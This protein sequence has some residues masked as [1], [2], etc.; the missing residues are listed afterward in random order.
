M[1]GARRL[2]SS[3][4]PITPPSSLICPPS[5]FLFPHYTSSVPPSLPPIFRPS[6]SHFLPR[7]PYFRTP[8][9]LPTVCHTRI[10]LPP[11]PEGAMAPESQQ[12]L[13][14][15]SLPGSLTPAPIRSEAGLDACSGGGVGGNDVEDGERSGRVD[16]EK[17]MDGETREEDNRAEDVREE[18]ERR[19][20]EGRKVVRMLQGRRW[21]WTDFWEEID[22]EVSECGSCRCLLV[23]S[24]SAHNLDRLSLSSPPLPTSL[25]TRRGCIF[26]N[27]GGNWSYSRRQQ[28]PRQQRGPASRE[29]VAAVSHYST[30]LFPAS[31]LPQLLL[32]GGGGGDG[33][34][35]GLAFEGQFSD[36]CGW[37]RG[38][39]EGRGE[40]VRFQ[41]A[42]ELGGVVQGGWLSGCGDFGV[43]KRGFATL[44]SPPPPPLTTLSP[45]PL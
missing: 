30:T 35:G 39:E 27:S 17:G 4:G 2:A 29:G 18:E 9:I 7:P 43:R 37:G 16:N 19:M 44:G 34:V 42:A 40:G 26:T 22:D 36:Y 28:R 25:L 15:P 31:P 41:G 13:S 23:V 6:T 3:H 12:P 5:L 24:A 11:P 14:T 21:A 32:W 38:V 1:R 45:P 33:G 8:T 20:T 10:H